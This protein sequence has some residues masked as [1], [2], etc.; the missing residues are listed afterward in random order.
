VQY[1]AEAIP[2]TETVINPLWREADKTVSA[3]RQNVRKLRFPDPSLNP[4]G[5]FPASY[6]RE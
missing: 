5:T 3:A 1:G 4:I 2:G 6:T